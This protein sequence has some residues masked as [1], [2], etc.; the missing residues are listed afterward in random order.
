LKNKTKK[1]VLALL[2][3]WPESPTSIGQNA[4]QNN[5]R[6][7]LSAGLALILTTSPAIILPVE[8]RLPRCFYFN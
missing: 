4:R 2:E 6:G 1:S 8:S 5:G 3:A 7:V